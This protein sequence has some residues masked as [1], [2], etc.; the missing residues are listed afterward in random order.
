MQKGLAQTVFEARHKRTLTDRRV[1]L[2]LHAQ[3]KALMWLLHAELT[4]GEHIVH[5]RNG[6]EYRLPDYLTSAW[7]ITAPD[8]YILRILW[9]FLAPAYV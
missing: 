8:K 6:R 5:C 2:Y 1:H 9:L 4:D 3:Q 7:M